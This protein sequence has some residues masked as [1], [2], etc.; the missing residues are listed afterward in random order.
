MIRA[1]WDGLTI[2]GRGLLAAAIAAAVV[3]VVLEQADLLRVA[4][5][6]ALLPTIALLLLVARRRRDLL[7]ISRS[8]GTPRAPVGSEVTVAVGVRND[9]TR[10]SATQRFAD[11]CE[12]A[13][14][15]E[16]RFVVDEL[17]P[18]ASAATTYT[19]TTRVRGQHHVGPAVLT[20]QD[21]FG[22]ARTR[23]AHTATDLIT[24]TP[25]ITPLVGRPAGA[26]GSGASEG[27]VRRAATAGSDDV[28][29]R[30]YRSGDELRRVHWRAT[31]RTGSLMVRQEEQPWES[32]AVLFL[33]TRARSHQAYPV[34]DAGDVQTP[35]TSSFEWAVHAVASIG[36]HLAV[37]E[38]RLRVVTG[39]SET[40]IHHGTGPLLDTLAAARPT[41]DDV[42]LAG[43]PH[44][45]A[46][47]LVV[48]VVGALHTDTDDAA[49]IA[50]L[51][52][53]GTHAVAIVLDT[54]TWSR[55]GPYRPGHDLLADP[56]RAA[57]WHAVVAARGD[58]LRDV[59]A[60]VIR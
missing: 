37:S 17:A 57:G 36:S 13:L 18:G 47:P 26:S 28:G 30:A 38:R 8:V 40:E 25:V 20:V 34:G 42:P 7:H 41:T 2:R 16:H 1:I 51:R 50:S 12:P 24:V 22:L 29:T 6:L 60:R 31:A 55:P 10:R 23:V 59:W 5:L 27:A 54:A 35:G 32:R 9:G 45:G 19:I 48:A 39:S 33:D 14:G 53:S 49:R 11:G 4:A 43:G 3:A 46:A 21:P 52:A 15:S 44:A 56:L 58:D